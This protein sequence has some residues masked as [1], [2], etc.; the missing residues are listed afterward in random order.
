M[1]CRGTAE[2]LPFHCSGN[3]ELFLE[4]LQSSSIFSKDLQFIPQQ[5]FN[6]SQIT[7][8]KIGIMMKMKS[9]LIPLTRYHDNHLFKKINPSPSILHTN[10]A[11]I[12]KH[13]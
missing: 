10:I 6:E 5:G 4:S 7:Y 9:F 12:G 11:S 1:H 13:Y 8:M 3:N 2:A